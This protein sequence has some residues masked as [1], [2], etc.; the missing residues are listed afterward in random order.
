MVRRSPVPPSPAF[1]AASRDTRT[2]RIE[3]PSYRRWWL[4]V[5]ATTDERVRALPGDE[6]IPQAIDTLT[7]GV[8]IRR[9]P[10][11]VW[12]WL[13]QMGAGS[14]GGWY[15]YDWLDNGRRPSASRIV[16]ALQHPAVGDIFPAMPGMTEGFTLLAIEP[17]RTLML[18][19]LAPDGT[20]EVTW[21]FVLDEVTPG[22]TRLLVRARG[23]P[24]YRFH[25][26]PLMLTRV[27]VRVVHFIMQRKQ[28]LGIASRASLG[29]AFVMPSHRS[30]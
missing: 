20:P 7:H 13:V 15:S 26:L 18:G 10:R 9:P 17:E 3:S 5:R 4:S 12:P 29:P 8:T 16:P 11:D 25:G 30:S 28:L 24:G 23:G 14:R 2:D 6:R 19:W 27:V 1:E 21:T 22:V